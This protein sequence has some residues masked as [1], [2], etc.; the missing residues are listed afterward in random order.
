MI[1][2]RGFGAAAVRLPSGEHEA[3]GEPRLSSLQRVDALVVVRKKNPAEA[4]AEVD[5][6]VAVALPPQNRCV[7][8]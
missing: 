4:K 2:K 7:W 3:A 8:M 6:A 1:L 5:D